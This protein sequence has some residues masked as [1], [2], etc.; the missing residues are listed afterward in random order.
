MNLKS[1]ATV[2]L[3]T[4]ITGAVTLGTNLAPAQAALLKFDFTTSG[5]AVLDPNAPD[6]SGSFFLDTSV[7]DQDSEVNQGIFLNAIRDF[8]VDGRTPIT[9][10]LWT[11]LE[12]GQTRYSISVNGTDFFFANSS[13]IDQLSS[14]PT[15]YQTQFVPGIPGSGDVFGQFYVASGSS[16]QSQ[17]ITG[18][19]VTDATAVPTPSL[20]FGLLG[21]GFLALKRKMQKKEHSSAEA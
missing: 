19:T 1:I 13:L 7:T 8:T 20:A 21:T 3:T 5:P 4:G 18:L 14:D 15:V 2:L 9:T 6:R 17:A 16:Y 12:N 10:S 11:S